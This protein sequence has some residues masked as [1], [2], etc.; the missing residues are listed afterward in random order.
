MRSWPYARRGAAAFCALIAAVTA[1]AIVSDGDG[2]TIAL[3]VLAAAVALRLIYEWGVASAAIRSTVSLTQAT[4]YAQTTQ[5]QLAPLTHPAAL[6]QP[7][8]VPA[9]CGRGARD[10]A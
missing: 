7:G 4:A 10:A 8:P 9:P 1:L 6:A 5:E 3:V 2:A